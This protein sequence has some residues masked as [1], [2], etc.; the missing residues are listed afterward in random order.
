MTMFEIAFAILLLAATCIGGLVGHV[1]GATAT[2]VG[3]FAPITAYSA[4]LAVAEIGERRREAKRLPR[5]TLVS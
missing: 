1:W 2:M 5:A 3:I 4:A